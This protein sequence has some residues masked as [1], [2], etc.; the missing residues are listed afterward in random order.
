MIERETD[1]LEARGEQIVGRVATLEA[2][3]LLKRDR[4]VR[5]FA[6]MESAIAGINS[7]QTA[8]A[9]LRPLNADG[10]SQ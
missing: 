1:A 5:Q 10:T 2:R 7:S 9:A 3:L 8:L 4:L 6:A